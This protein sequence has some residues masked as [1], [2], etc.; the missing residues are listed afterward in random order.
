M[1]L[2]RFAEFLDAYTREI[3]TNC[4]L[5]CTPKIISNKKALE[6]QELSCNNW[7]RWWDSNSRTV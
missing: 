6:K 7:R 2:Y 1:K 4:T 5:N 3:F